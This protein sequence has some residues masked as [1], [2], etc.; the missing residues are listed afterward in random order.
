LAIGAACLAGAAVAGVAAVGALSPAAG[1]LPLLA[2][3]VVVVATIRYTGYQW[4]A[5]ASI[6]AISWSAALGIAQLPLYP[7]FGW[8]AE[9]WLLLTVP[10]AALAAGAIVGAGRSGWQ[11]LTAPVSFQAPPI[12][13]QTTLAA[14]IVGALGWVVFFVQI[15]AVPLLSDQIDIARFRPFGLPTLLATRLGYVAVIIAIPSFF[16]SRER[17]ERVGFAAAVAIAL[18]PMVLSGGRLYPVSAVAIGLVATVLVRG[19]TLRVVL[20]AVAAGALV[21]AA[22]SVV[23]FVRLDQ[24][25]DVD[26]EFKQHLDRELKD[27]RPGVLIW[28]IPVQVAAASSMYT[29]ADLADTHAFE[30]DPSPGIYSTKFIDRVR[31]SGD[32]EQV[33]RTTARFSL[34][35][36]TYVG[37]WY[38]DFGHQG[39]ITLSI[40][41]GLAV[42]VLWRWWRTRPAPL[43][44][45]LY[46]YSAF[47]LFYALYLNYWTVH[48]V[49]VADVA[50][51]M[52][53]TAPSR[54]G[55]EWVR[56]LARRYERPASAEPLDARV[57]N[58]PG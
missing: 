1:Y 41:W 54:A 37:P 8:N 20:A 29:L 3:P 38:A 46:A 42:G 9:A 22:A 5:P 24:Q 25:P 40:A 18:I 16:L 4:L 45:L 57:S 30:M 11:R 39:V 43:S 34:I 44:W 6:F 49:W 15:G 53:L 31:T 2:L 55:V 56:G 17:N 47:W 50:F 33:T 35:T 51:F 32:L 48:G 10:P 12:A 27:S 36:S 58:Q 7:S 19:L 26:N 28:T 52:A 14:A 13:M 23:F 21:V